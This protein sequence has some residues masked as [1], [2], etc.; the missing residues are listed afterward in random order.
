MLLYRI[1]QEGFQY[2]EIGYA[3]A[4]ITVFLFFVL[5]FSLVSSGWPSGASSTVPRDALMG[6]AER[7]EVGSIRVA[8]VA[9]AIAEHAILIAIGILILVPFIWMIATSL[10]PAGP[11]LWR[12]ARLV[13]SQFAAGRNYGKALF[14]VPMLA[15]C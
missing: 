4:L 11:D 10:K 3:S 5:A 2:F 15:S 9:V 1:Y 13:P 7:L 14:S 6:E 8:S 12:T